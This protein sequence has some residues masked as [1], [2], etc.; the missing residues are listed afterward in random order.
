MKKNIKIAMVFMLVM[1]FGAQAA[2]YDSYSE[3]SNSIQLKSGTLSLSNFPPVPESEY[4]PS[5]VTHLVCHYIENLPVKPKSN[6]ELLLEYVRA[7][8]N[9]HKA[10]AD[11]NNRE[12]YKV[13]LLKE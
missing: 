4:I 3:K 1:G 5:I 12:D 7:Y 11:A 13:E 2:D 6:S 10:V 8:K 9:I